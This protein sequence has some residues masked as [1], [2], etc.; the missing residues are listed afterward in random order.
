MIL[1]RYLV[2]EMVKPFFIG[3]FGFIVFMISEMM[4]ILIDHVVSRGVD[5]VSVIKIIVYRIPA[6]AVISIPVAI[7]FAVI[8][9]ITK[10]E[11]NFEITSMRILGLR[12][13]H[14]T[15]PFII[16]SFLMTILNFFLN[17]KVVPLTMKISEEVVK[18][19]IIRAG[20]S[21]IQSDV[22]FKMPDGKIVIVRNVNKRDRV[23]ENIVISDI[24]VGNFSRIITSTRGYVENL[25]II[26]EDG[27]LID[28]GR[29]GF[30]KTQVKFEKLV[31]P[32]NLS[33]DDIIKELKNPWEMSYEELKKELESRE[34][35]GWKDNFLK[36]QLYLKFSL[37]I[38]CIV[39]V[40][41]SLPLAVIFA[42][43]GKFIG[44]L[45]SVFLI[46]VY[47]SLFSF[48]AALGKNN[49]LN[50]FLAAFGANFVMLTIGIYLIY[51][52]ER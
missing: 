36:T 34:K 42:N 19:K 38:S 27:Y 28:F 49:L 6:F 25:D 52:I 7:L 50:P 48:F 9:S 13:Y 43:R 29:D 51:R 40:I 15:L 46:F 1:Y 33:F 8:N 18:Q 41:L 5:V 4:F 39:V 12:F 47:Y 14:I 35:L 20:I 16:V 32:F 31:I 22:F 23:L 3:L 17:E 37:P 11:S 45:I 10:L 26:L 44:L 24:R 2:T 21:F 30:V